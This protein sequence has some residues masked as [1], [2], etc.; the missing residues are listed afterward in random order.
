MASANV[1]DVILPKAM[2]L[3]DVVSIV[4]EREEYFPYATCSVR[5]IDDDWVYLFRPYVRTDDF[6]YIGGVIA[7]IGI[8]DYKIPRD[9]SIP[10]RLLERPA[11]PR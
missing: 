4:R 9:S 1:G 2:L 10:Y 3:R 11:A 7:L 5:N 6:S 8:E